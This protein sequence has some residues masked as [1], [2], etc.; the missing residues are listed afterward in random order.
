MVR[1]WFRTMEWTSIPTKHLPAPLHVPLGLSNLIMFWRFYTAIHVPK[2]NKSS[3]QKFCN[4]KMYCFLKCINTSNVLE[5]SNIC[6]SWSYFKIHTWSLISTAVTV[7]LSFLKKKS[8][9][10]DQEKRQWN[11]YLQRAEAL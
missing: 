9:N 2:I 5:K 1:E 10:P 3:I 4:K 8:S 11:S 7:H 6:I